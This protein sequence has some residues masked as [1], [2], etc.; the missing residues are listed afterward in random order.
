MS[1]QG[2]ATSPPA[3]RRRTGGA[4]RNGTRRARAVGARTAVLSRD[5]GARGRGCPHRGRRGPG[6]LARW[7]A[8]DGAHQPPGCPSDAEV[9]GRRLSAI[10]TFRCTR[11]SRLSPSPPTAS[12]SS[13]AQAAAK[14]GPSSISGSSSGFEIKAA[15]RHRD[16]ID[17]VLF[18]RRPLD[19]LLA[20]QRIASSVRSQSAG[21]SPIEIG[22]TDMPRRC[23]LGI[24]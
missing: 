5:A 16:G 1:R 2:C 22:P 21:G 13:C 12:G 14:G 18:T 9:G 17:A 20:T 3:H 7:T 11:S 24:E 15:S 10:S 23:A 4:G 8:S 19:R 6:L